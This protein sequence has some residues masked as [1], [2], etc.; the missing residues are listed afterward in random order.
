M[1]QSPS[2]ASNTAPL[3]EGLEAAAALGRV[4]LDGELC[5]YQQDRLDFAAL[6]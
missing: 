3:T 5:A 2:G 1:R 6:S 4:V